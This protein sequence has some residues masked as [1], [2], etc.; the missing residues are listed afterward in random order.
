LGKARYF[1][2]YAC[3][4]R[5]IRSQAFHLP[6]Q[7]P[8]DNLNSQSTVTY[9]TMDCEH[10][11]RNTH[12]RL[13]DDFRLVIATGI[14]YY[15]WH[16]LNVRPTNTIARLR[17]SQTHAV[18]LNTAVTLVVGARCLLVC[19]LCRGCSRPLHQRASDDVVAQHVNERVEEYVAVCCRDC[20]DSSG[21]GDNAARFVIR[22]LTG[23]YRLT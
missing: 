14:S 11:R 10:R 16:N 17:N 12:R 2:L 15:R 6:E 3:A 13:P 19:Q 1:L 4:G 20:Q 8:R 22:F 18:Q 9:A 21:V 5:N 7:N 23:K